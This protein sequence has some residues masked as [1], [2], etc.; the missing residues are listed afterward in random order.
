MFQKVLYTFFS[1]V[2]NIAAT[3]GISVVIS[4][5]LGAEGRGEQALILLGITLVCLFTQVAGGSA[6]VYLTP[7]YPGKRLL[8]VAYVWVLLSGVIGWTIL[9]FFGAFQSFAVD[10]LIIS[11][12]HSIWTANAYYLLGKEKTGVFN[13][14]NFIYL[15]MILGNLCVQW[16]FHELDL[17]DYIDSLYY[18]HLVSL[19]YSFAALRGQLAGEKPEL[20]LL[21]GKFIHHGGFIQLA[22][23]AQLLKYRIHFYIIVLYLGDSALGIYSN[24]LAIAEAVWVISRSIATVQFAKVANLEDDNEARKLTVNYTWISIAASAAAMVV[25][26][27]FPDEFFTLVFG[28]DFTGI[29]E[30]LIYLSVAIIALSASN[31]LSHYFSGKGRNH[32]NFIGSAIGLAV[33]AG[34]GY[35]LIPDQGLKGAAIASSVAFLVTAVFHWGMFVGAKR[36]K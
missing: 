24:A 6:L 14:L 9:Y 17:K 10:I 22:N 33:T 32:V 19:I 30:I 16:Y 8:G 20:K 28:K 2:S 25:L 12:I 11:L 35:L 15:L 29:H 7:K 13:F 26:L 23:V 34:L 36:T 21:L 5:A 3:L 1:R 4:N 27:C 31:L 18:G